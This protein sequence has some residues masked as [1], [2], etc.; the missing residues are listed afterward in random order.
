MNN[1]R[2][3]HLLVSQMRNISENMFLQDHEKRMYHSRMMMAVFAFFLM[4]FMFFSERESLR[5]REGEKHFFL[6]E[7]SGF[8]T[9][10]TEEKKKKYM[11]NT[12][13]DPLIFKPVCINRATESL[14]E[15]IPG[16]G[17][18]TAEKIIAARNR[19]GGFSRC[20]ELIEVEGLGKAK[21]AKIARYLRVGNNECL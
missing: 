2:K 13:F 6:L 20:E 14:L 18:K 3:L 21:Y 16:I 8:L 11:N 9:V 15:T 5:Q 12:I 17:R 1:K 7:N 4:A 10:S 19:A